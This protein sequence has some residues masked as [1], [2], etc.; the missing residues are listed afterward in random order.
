LK[1]PLTG[2]LLQVKNTLAL[3]HALALTKAAQLSYSHIRQA[4]EANG[5]SIPESGDTSVD[6]SLYQ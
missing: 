2:D 6:D 3:A 5:I 1:P 4:L